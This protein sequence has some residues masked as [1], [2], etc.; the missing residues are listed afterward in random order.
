MCVY[1]H[2]LVR[3]QLVDII[4]A[5]VFCFILGWVEKFFSDLYSKIVYMR[6]QMSDTGLQTGKHIKYL[7]GLS[8]TYIAFAIQR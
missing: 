6:Y 7:V 1:V 5:I 4:I 3:N 2:L 8:T